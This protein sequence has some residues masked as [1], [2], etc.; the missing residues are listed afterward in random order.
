MTWVHNLDPFAIQLTETFGIRWYGLA[1][2]LGLITGYYAVYRLTKKGGTQ[3][4][5]DQI[6][7]FTTYCAIGVLGGGR[8]GYCLFYAPDLLLSF[9]SSFPFWGV[10]KVNEGGM[11][12]HGGILGVM[13][14]CYLY[15]RFNKMSWLHCLDLTVFGSALGFFFG[16]LAN[17]I[18]GELYGREAPAGLSW[19]VKFPQE[20]GL[21]AQT[22]KARLEEL[23]PVAELLGE[24]KTSAGEVIKLNAGVWQNWL[25]TQGRDFTSRVRIQETI[26]AIIQA[27]QSGNVA[28]TKA[29]GEVLTPRYPSQLIQALLEG[30][31]VFLVLVVLWRRPQKPG[32]IAAAFGSLYCVARIIGEQ[33]RMPDIGIGF[34]ALGL[35]RGQWISIGMLAVGIAFFIWAWLRQAPRLGGWHRLPGDE[36]PLVMAGV[37]VGVVA[38]VSGAGSGGSAS[39]RAE[40]RRAKKKGKK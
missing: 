4:R 35:T 5:L 22:D 17:F 27:V 13:L 18:N 37:G 11:S 23:K 10:F 31:L 6:A 34:Q 16:R 36:D 2:L 24:F 21:W 14:V 40:A 7:D 1:Y 19:A 15:G 26:E 30:L 39:T 25:D 20:M 3:F 29:L 8:V 32:M 38:G 28:L 33:F 12:S 9:D